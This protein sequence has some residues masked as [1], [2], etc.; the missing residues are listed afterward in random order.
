[1]TSYDNIAKFTYYNLHISNSIQGLIFFT[2][3]LAV[4]SMEPVLIYTIVR[5]GKIAPHSFDTFW[6]QAII[7]TN[8]GYFTDAYMRHSAS[9]S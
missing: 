8:D 3:G 5:S 9:M 2:L 6:R 7:W 1:M 4:S